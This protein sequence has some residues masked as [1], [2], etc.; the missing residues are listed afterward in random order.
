MHKLDDALRASAGTL[1]SEVLIKVDV[2]GYE[3]AVIKGG[4]HTFER[5]LACI[6][7]VNIDKLYDQQA[8]FDRL[9]AQL[10]ELGLRYAGNLEQVYAD[11][12]RVIYVDAV[13]RR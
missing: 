9:V 7:E 2:Q 6:V 3:E 10:H 1:D 11:N 13:F 12:G 8:S 5:A 4:R